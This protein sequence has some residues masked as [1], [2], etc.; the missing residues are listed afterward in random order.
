MG[1]SRAGEFDRLICLCGIDAVTCFDYHPTRSSPLRRSMSY[2]PILFP[3]EGR[4]AR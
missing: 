2:V 4:H 3:G 1:N